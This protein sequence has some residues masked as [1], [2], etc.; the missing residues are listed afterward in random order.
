M[1]GVKPI[2]DLTPSS[3][4]EPFA[5]FGNLLQTQPQVSQRPTPQPSAYHHEGSAVL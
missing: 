1:Y 4:K 2:P 5:K 3:R